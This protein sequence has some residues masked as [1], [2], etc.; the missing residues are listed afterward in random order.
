MLIPGFRRE[1]EEDENGGE[2]SVPKETAVFVVMV[3]TVAMMFMVTQ[4][5]YRLLGK[6]SFM[7]VEMLLLVPAMVFLIGEKYNWKQVLRLNGISWYLGLVTLI[8]SLGVSVLFDEIDRLVALIYTMPAE[9]SEAVIKEIQIDNF[10][11]FLSLT[12]GAVLAAAIVEEILFRGFLQ[13]TLEKRRGATSAVTTVSLL[14]ALIHLNPWWVIQ[15][16]LLAFLLGVLS[17]RAD[18]IVPP[19]IIHIVNNALGLWS[20]NIDLESIPYYTLGRHVSPIFLIPAIFITIW[21]L[22]QFF[23]LTAHLHP[24]EKVDYIIDD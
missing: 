24:G 12:L 2:R 18:S 1:N 21:S 16:I 22:K 4:P 14:F 10:P 11:D 20:A 13:R 6:F 7:V 5:L 19:M 17:W 9:V 15:I 23:R 3:V 8:M